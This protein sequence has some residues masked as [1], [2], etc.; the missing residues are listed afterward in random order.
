MGGFVT[1]SP[2]DIYRRWLPFGFLSSHTR[3]HGAPPTEPWLISESFTKAFRDCAE[4]KYKLMPYV[5]A[6]AKDCCERG[7]PMVRALFVEFPKDPGSWLIEDEYLFGSQILVAPLLESGES[8]LC[9][10]PEGKWIDYQSG[11]VYESG[12]REVKT[13]KIPAV[14]LVRDGSLIPHVPLAQHT[15]QIDWSKI[16]W[17]SYKADAKK[18]VGYLF[19]PGDTTIQRVEK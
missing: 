14:I 7:L 12:F 17:K 11:S 10:L 18:C 1:A 16:E 5:Y 15:G 13:G 6:Q 2:E 19:K 3:A 9:Y 4:L 8:R